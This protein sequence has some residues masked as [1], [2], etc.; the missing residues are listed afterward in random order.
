MFC[1]G[2]LSLGKHFYNK[3]LPKYYFL[4]CFKSKIFT[5]T[6]KSDIKVSNK[7]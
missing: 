2:R 1:F 7:N 6:L 3:N 4:K 5:L